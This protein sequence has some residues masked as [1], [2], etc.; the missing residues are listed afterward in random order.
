MRFVNPTQLYVTCEKFGG[1]HLG[2][3]GFMTGRQAARQ[4]NEIWVRFKILKLAIDQ[5]INFP[6]CL[7]KVLHNF[8]IFDAF[9]MLFR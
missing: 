6:L 9:L 1:L 4:A 3:P 7:T 2:E 8:N 5:N